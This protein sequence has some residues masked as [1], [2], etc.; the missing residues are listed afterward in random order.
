MGSN[1]KG[2]VCVAGM[3]CGTAQ[4]CDFDKNDVI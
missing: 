1:H 4:L 2:L 3:W